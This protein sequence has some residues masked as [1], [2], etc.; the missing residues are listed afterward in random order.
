MLLA[1][2]QIISE[3]HD[4]CT[5]F[6]NQFIDLNF[7]EAGLTSWSTANVIAHAVIHVWIYLVRF[8]SECYK[9]M[10]WLIIHD[11]DF[12]DKASES[13]FVDDDAFSDAMS[14]HHWLLTVA[15]DSTSRPS[16]NLSNS[17]CSKGFMRLSASCCLMRM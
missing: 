4:I 3:S 2:D 1:Y 13:M 5:W 15:G 10:M 16:Q 17:D 7:I 12:T 8:D 14:D 6:F 11:C 9:Q